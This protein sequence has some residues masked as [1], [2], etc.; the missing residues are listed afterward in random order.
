MS[1]SP[2]ADPRSAPTASQVN[3]S[4]GS[5]ETPVVA[6]TT[7][8]LE[9]CAATYSGAA[10]RTRPLPRADAVLAAQSFANRPPPGTVAQ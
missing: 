6:D 9:V 2:A 1:Q 4:Q 3:S 8:G 5:H 7:S 10:T